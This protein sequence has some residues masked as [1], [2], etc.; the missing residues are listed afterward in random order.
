M[1]RLRLLFGRKHGDRNCEA[2]LDVSVLSF[3]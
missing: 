3:P 2:P 1:V